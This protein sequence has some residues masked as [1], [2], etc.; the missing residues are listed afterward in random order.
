MGALLPDVLERGEEVGPKVLADEGVETFFVT[1]EASAE[2]GMFGEEGGAVGEG[3][4]ASV[5]DWD[6]VAFVEVVGGSE[7]KGV[8]QR[9]EKKGGTKGRERGWEVAPKE[10]ERA[11]GTTKGAGMD[12][13]RSR[14]ISL[15]EHRHDWR[16]R[17]EGTAQTACSSDSSGRSY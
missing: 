12:W 7:D 15:K 1:E 4:V 2:R 17:E 13:L 10:E 3:A 11:N 16:A 5:R 8:L 14:P 9:K 6:L